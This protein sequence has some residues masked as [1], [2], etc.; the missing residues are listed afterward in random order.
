[1][2]VFQKSL[3]KEDS[4]ARLWIMTPRPSSVTQLPQPSHREDATEHPPQHHDNT[5]S[6]PQRQPS[7]T[8]TGRA[9]P[10]PVMKEHPRCSISMKRRARRPSELHRL[11]PHHHCL[12]T[13]PV[14]HATVNWGAC[15]LQLITTP[16]DYH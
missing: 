3:D 9:Q 16:I 14:W 2:K 15:K 4:S 8:L 1:M 12:D 11:N 6:P 7:H 10:T 13:A 5:A